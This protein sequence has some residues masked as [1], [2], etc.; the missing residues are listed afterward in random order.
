MKAVCYDRRYRTTQFSSSE[1]A[2]LVFLSA[3]ISCRKVE[4]AF[5]ER[6]N[7]SSWRNNRRTQAVWS[8]QPEKKLKVRL[9]CTRIRRRFGAGEEIVDTGHFAGSSTGAA[10]RGGRHVLFCLRQWWIL[11]EISSGNLT[12]DQVVVATVATTPYR[13]VLRGRSGRFYPTDALARLQRRPQLPDGGTS[14]VGIQGQSGVQ[15][16]TDSLSGRPV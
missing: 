15:I 12:A 7:G 2:R 4:H 3:G 13:A 5:L 10:A 8:R 1:A 14:I 9:P 6:V 11:I 16:M